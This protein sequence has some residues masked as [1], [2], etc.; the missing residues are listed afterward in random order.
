MTIAAERVAQAPDV[1]IAEVTAELH[2][3]HQRLDA[4]E[5]AGD[6]TTSMRAVL[7]WSYGALPPSARRLFRLVAAHPAPELDLA[8]AAAAAG[9]PMVRVRR[10]VDTLAGLHLVRRTAGNRLALHD[11]VR[12][13]AREQL[14]AEPDA[15][16]DEAR[17]RLLDWYLHTV[18]HACW[19]LDP[20]TRAIA[21]PPPSADLAPLTFDRDEALRWCESERRS[22]RAVAEAAADAGRHEAVG[23]LATLY[24]TYLDV[25]GQPGEVGALCRLALR[26]VR[27]LG[28][29]KEEALALNRLGIAELLLGEFGGAEEH[30]RAALAL[31]RARGDRDAEVETLT[32]LGRVLSAAGRFGDA[33][34]VCEQALELIDRPEKGWR[35]WN[36]LATALQQAGRLGEALDAVARALDAADGYERVTAHDTR[37]RTFEAVGMRAYTRDTRAWIHLGL[38]QWD[39]ALADFRHA[40]RKAVELG[41]WRLE[42][43]ALEGA[44]QVLHRRGE[45]A[46]AHRV[47]ASALEVLLDAE[48][49]VAASKL[50]ETMSTC[51]AKAAS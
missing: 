5:T 33:V 2:N 39:E 40:H 44:G 16:R 27:A 17:A 28:D 8:A 18:A 50:R 34:R 32:N 31:D 24:W 3:D 10:G 20:R 7:D 14:D 43:A 36:N 35:A 21:L 11:L 51:C 13:Y 45:Q 12:A 38:R 29:R 25:R 49:H 1:P 4:L 9:V 41:E 15:E 26:S 47:W 37:Q 30:M 42:A 22:V 46:N 23:N 19:A 48:A 6:L